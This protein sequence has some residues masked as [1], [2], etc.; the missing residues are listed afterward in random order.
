M[1]GT[2]SGVP[3]LVNP[4]PGSGAGSGHAGANPKVSG[5]RPE[6]LDTAVE[7]PG[8]IPGTLVSVTGILGTGRKYVPRGL[9]LQGVK[10]QRGGRRV[11]KTGPLCNVKAFRM[12]PFF[13]HGISPEVPECPGG[14]VHKTCPVVLG[15]VSG[16]PG[17]KSGPWGWLCGCRAAPEFALRG[18]IPTSAG[19]DPQ[20]PGVGF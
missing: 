16:I 3:E 12:F 11:R 5:T 7:T 19:A 18:P 6:S 9:H 13:I 4:A 8:P 20:H 15:A 10:V 2:S 14:G 17:S 1:P